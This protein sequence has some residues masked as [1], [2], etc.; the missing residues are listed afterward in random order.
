MSGWQLWIDEE[1]LLL[2]S[3]PH[4]QTGVVQP[5]TRE[6]APLLQLYS[7]VL[8][9]P[10]SI[11]FFFHFFPSNCGPNLLSLPKS[12]ITILGYPIPYCGVPYYICFFFIFIYICLYMYIMRK[13][14]CFF[15]FVSF[16]INF[17]L[18]KKIVWLFFTL[19]FP[20]QPF[21]YKRTFP[22]LK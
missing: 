7:R 8:S 17:L 5:F 11:L 21:N 3:S 10:S 16:P 2:S 14:K 6:D 12:L 13:K 4:T 9:Y 22:K 19:F 15:F 1:R 18:I 20:E